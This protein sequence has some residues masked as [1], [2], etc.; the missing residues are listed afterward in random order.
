DV[1][2]PRD[3]G[4]VAFD[5][6]GEI[7]PHAIHGP[8][9]AGDDGKPAALRFGVELGDELAEDLGRRTVDRLEGDTRS[10][11]TNERNGRVAVGLA[12]GEQRRN[13]GRHDGS[14]RG[15]TDN[16]TLRR[17]SAAANSSQRHEQPRGPS[18]YD[19]AIG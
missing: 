4:E 16:S 13:G 1:P 3:R 19:A 2:G 5:A 14:H 17:G 15:K 8:A 6:G 9:F 10:A 7:A 18:C 12:S 11:R